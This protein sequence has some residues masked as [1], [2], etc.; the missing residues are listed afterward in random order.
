MGSSTAFAVEPDIDRDIFLGIMG[1]TIPLR[2]ITTKEIECKKGRETWTETETLEHP[3]AQITNPKEAEVSSG[4]TGVGGS[5]VGADG[6]ADPAAVG[7]TFLIVNGKKIPF[8]V[9]GGLTGKEGGKR[10]RKPK[11]FTEKAVKIEWNGETYNF[12]LGVSQSLPGKLYFWGAAKPA[13]AREAV[14]EELSTLDEILG[15]FSL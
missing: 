7:E 11:V 12:T 3:I 10:T 9:V 2:T 13:S 14:P 4:I 15:D 6:N 5:I 8:T 1:K